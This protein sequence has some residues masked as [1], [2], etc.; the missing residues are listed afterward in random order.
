MA[1]LRVAA[2]LLLC[3]AGS[4]KEDELSTGLKLKLEQMGADSMA[5]RVRTSRPHMPPTPTTC[6]LHTPPPQTTAA[7]KAHHHAPFHCRRVWVAWRASSAVISPSTRRP[8]S[9]C[10]Y[11]AHPLHVACAACACACCMCMLHVHVRVAGCM[12]HVACACCICMCMCMC[13]LHVHVHVC[14]CMCMCSALHTCSALTLRT[15]ARTAPHRPQRDAAT[16]LP[17]DVV[18][19]ACLLGGAAAGG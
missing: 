1:L 15:H 5:K 8:G 4:A 18:L 3:T 6:T 17:Q 10:M 11:T 7:A 9:M 14:M 19:N 2:L 13:M 16:D 12:L